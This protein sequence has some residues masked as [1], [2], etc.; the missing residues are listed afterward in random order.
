MCSCHHVEDTLPKL[1]SQMAARKVTGVMTGGHGDTVLA[2]TQDTALL[3][4]QL[5]GSEVVA[6][7]ADMVL[8]PGAGQALSAPH[9][10]RGH[11]PAPRR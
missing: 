4:D 6:M 2:E 5:Q 11:P 1:L 7:M 3:D 10:H 8:T 9:L